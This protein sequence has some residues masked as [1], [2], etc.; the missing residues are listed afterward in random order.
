MENPHNQLQ[1]S[2]ES[3][4]PNPALER[5]QSQLK[6]YHTLWVLARAAGWDVSTNAFFIMLSFNISIDLAV[7][8]WLILAGLNESTHDQAAVTLITVYANTVYLASEGPLYAALAPLSEQVSLRNTARRSGQEDSQAVEAHQQPIAEIMQVTFLL[9]KA[10]GLLMTVAMVFAEPI[11]V[12]VCQ[13]NPK[14]ADIAG[15]F[16]QWNSLQVLPDL[17]R[18]ASEQIIFA[19]NNM[20]YATYCGLTGCVVG[21]ALAYFLAFAL[22][23]GIRG[24]A[25]ARDAV[26]WATTTLYLGRLLL[27]PQFAELEL[28]SLGDQ[29]NLV[30]RL[31]YLMPTIKQQ[32]H[33]GAPISLNMLNDAFFVFTI[34]ALSGLVS[35]D[36]QA[37]MSYIMQSFFFLVVAQLAFA[38]ANLNKISRERGSE[39]TPWRMR[40]TA[41]AGLGA[42]LLAVLP[43]LCTLSAYPKLL[44]MITGGV[45]AEVESNIDTAA[46]IMF[47]GFFADVARM[48]M[49]FQLRPYEH[50]WGPMV[51]SS[52]GLWSGL[53][54][55]M[56]IGQYAL[57][58]PLSMAL[59]GSAYTLGIVL[60]LTAIA[61]LWFNTLIR[62]VVVD[63]SSRDN[64]VLGTMTSRMHLGEGEAARG[65]E[66]EYVVSIG[67]TGHQE[68]LATI[69]NQSHLGVVTS[70]L[71]SGESQAAKGGDDIREG[72][73]VVSIGKVDHRETP[74]T[75]LE[76]PVFGGRRVQSCPLLVGLGP[77]MFSAT[78]QAMSTDAHRTYTSSDV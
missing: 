72:E 18:I 22:S 23:M 28:F 52:L 77:Q 2:S 20:L 50:L 51:K 4:S 74:A 58:Q 61:P 29:K 47:P 55:I 54:V 65:D 63:A 48:V 12:H 70:P 53:A 7:N 46:R 76:L 42:A 66:G 34:G 26:A 3:G 68:T 78:T 11:L 9:A 35:V 6:D 24:I 45:S 17:I 62:D 10:M 15:L 41:I 39:A 64:R 75:R 44:G 40:V 31:Q 57:N 33:D 30:E 16:L 60:G 32:L 8:G 19:S 38:I 49:L 69:G 43:L 21:T 5:R 67:E 14:T 27:D 13:Q 36:A 1:C 71:H 25:I 56:L 59:I 73:C 37:A